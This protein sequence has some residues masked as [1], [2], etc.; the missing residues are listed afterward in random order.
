MKQIEDSKIKLIL[1]DILIKIDRICRENSLTYFLGFGTLLGAIRHKGFIP[2]DDDVDIMM[3][4]RDY[5]KLIEL[6]KGE[7]DG[8]RFITFETDPQYIYSFGKICDTSTH[9]REIGYKEVQNMGVY[10]DVFPIDN[11]PNSIRA[12]KWQASKLRLLTSLLYSSAQTHYHRSARKWYYEPLKFALYPAAKLFGTRFWLKAVS[13]LAQK[14]NRQPSKYC[15]VNT[16]PT[17]VRILERAFFTKRI[18]WEFEGYRFFVPQK[19]DAVLKA[20]YGD[21]LKLPPPE[22]RITKHN[23]LAYYT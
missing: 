17:K 2:W 14:Y 3:P 9:L 20:F 11:Q 5:N 15:G 21:Y 4:R 8:L 10:V 18:E 19:Y 16:A 7:R 6:M 22:K 13:N 12:A 1:L 23:F